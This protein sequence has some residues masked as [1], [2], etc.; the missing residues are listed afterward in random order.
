MKGDTQMKLTPPK[1]VTWWVAVI[2]GVLGLLGHFG[3]IAALSPYAFWLVAAG[4]I[5]L[6]IATLVE[7]L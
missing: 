5:L 6:A 3:T 4:L 2:L 1:V 7:N